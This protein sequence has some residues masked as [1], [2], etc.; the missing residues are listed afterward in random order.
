VVSLSARWSDTEP[1]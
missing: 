1:T